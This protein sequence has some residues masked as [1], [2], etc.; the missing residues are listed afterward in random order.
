MSLIKGKELK[1]LYGDKFYKIIRNDMT[2]NKYVYKLGENVDTIEFN[3]TRECSEGGLYFTIKENVRLYITYRIKVGI[4]NIDD[5]ENVW[6]EEDK[7]KVHKLCLIE[8]ISLEEHINTLKED[9]IIK[10][11]Q[12][13]KELLKFVK[14]Q[15]E[16]ICLEA[17]RFI[18]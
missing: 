2:H 17:V 16:I 9:E 18:K 12:I 3:P 7:F 5:D 6:C 10:Y 1:K 11:V 15:T 8:I 4:I 14:N 13:D